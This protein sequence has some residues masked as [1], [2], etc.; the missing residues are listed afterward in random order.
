MEILKENIN[1]L[2]EI[3]FQEIVSIRRHLHKYPELSFQEEKTSEFICSKLDEWGV[4]YRKG[5]VK[6]GI[7]AEL[8]GKNPGK[9]IGFRAD[10]DA[11][12]IFENND[13]EYASMHKGVMHACGHDV[14]TA[15]L[16]GA[17]RIL[18]ELID[19]WSGKIKFVFQPGE[20]RIP[21]GAKLMLEEN[22]FGEEEPVL[23][24]AQH[25]YPDLEAGKV[26]FRS[27]QYMA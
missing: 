23:M 20:E 6:T 17:I 15:S 19:Q 25:V 12:P 27:G 26:G 18:K 2:A 11:L 9:V 7:V 22:L 4:S 21:G 3:Y 24:V 5:I 14:H 8:E 10:M 13:F 16:L 1:K